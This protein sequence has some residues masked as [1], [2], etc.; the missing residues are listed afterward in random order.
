MIVL[1]GIVST[2]H[3]VFGVTDR[4]LPRGLAEFSIL[5]FTQEQAT[6]SLRVT[7]NGNRTQDT[8]VIQTGNSTI[9]EYY[10]LYDKNLDATTIRKTYVSQFYS[11]TGEFPNEQWIMKI[12]FAVNASLVNLPVGDFSMQ[13]PTINYEGLLYISSSQREDFPD[14]GRYGNVYSLVAYINRSKG[15]ASQLTS[16]MIVLPQV[17]L[18]LAWFLEISIVIDVIL[19]L[20]RVYCLL[21]KSTSK[22][23]ESLRSKIDGYCL[24]NGGYFTIVIGVLFFLPIYGL[25]L[26]SLETPIPIT[27]GDLVLISQ[28]SHYAWILV[29]SFV[30]SLITSGSR[31]LWQK[32]ESK[33]H[34]VT[35]IC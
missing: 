34:S 16:S 7:I 33:C 26:R 3:Q 15:V 17:L 30:V 28:T 12:Q 32:K 31:S 14:L 22:S 4:V 23:I 19:F 13:L 20:L 35:G 24:L 18:L 1:V 9:I 2:P 25:T 5:A 8:L 27:Q 21:S 6:W 10:A 11:V 29:F